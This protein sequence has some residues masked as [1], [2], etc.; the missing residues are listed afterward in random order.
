MISYTDVIGR[1]HSFENKRHL[2]V[3]LYLDATG[4]LWLYNDMSVPYIDMLTG[5]HKLHQ[6]TFTI[7]DKENVTWLEAVSAREMYPED[8]RIYTSRRAE[9]AEISYRGLSPSE[10]GF[11]EILLDAGYRAGVTNLDGRQN[12]DHSHPVREHQGLC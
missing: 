6:I 7:I 4:A 5:E 11:G 8:S 1:T 12:E 9:E 10:I 2:A 3:A